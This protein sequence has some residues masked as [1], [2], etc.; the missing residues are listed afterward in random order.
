MTKSVL[1]E[2][3]LHMNCPKC[4]KPMRKV[5]WEITNNFK[6]GK[7]FKEYDKFTYECRDDDIWVT[8]EIP[9][10]KEASNKQVK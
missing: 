3:N 7:D 8:T 4:S 6:V 5:R 1:W 2:Y 10:T 9:L